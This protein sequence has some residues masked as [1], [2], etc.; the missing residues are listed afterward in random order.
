MESFSLTG[1]KDS[2][3]GLIR[4]HIDLIE[5]IVFALGF[6]ESLLFVSLF[7]PSTA[8]FLAIGGLHSAA[9]GAFL[10][11]WIAGS[12]GAFLGD[13]VSYSLG[14]YFKAE[15]GGMWP[16]RDY[17]EWYVAARQF[18]KR[19][20]IGGVIVSKF[21]GAMR[22]FMPV[23]AGAMGMRWPSFLFAS[24]VSSFVWA[25]AFLA[26]GYGLMWFVS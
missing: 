16:L 23:V 10:P 9:G 3:L 24:L 6:G 11:V 15:I 19:W 26:P 21:M 14:R 13:I 17:P 25:G 7:I 20:G 22:P 18:M 2:I 12:M 8:L 4:E 5:P 1:L